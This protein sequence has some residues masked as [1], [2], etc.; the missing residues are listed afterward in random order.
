MMKSE[1]SILVVEDDLSWQRIY[2]AILARQ[3]YMVQVA[4]SKV[5]ALRKLEQYMFDIAVVD[6]R[7]IDEEPKNF[8]G[9]EVVKQLRDRS[10]STR[11]IVNSG[12]LTDEIKSELQVLGV[13]GV[14]KK[15]GKNKE[16]VELVDR[17]RP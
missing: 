9:I 15:H 12:Y 4:S 8:E 1:C 3:G 2:K 16:L 6:L 7:L 13:E 5:E 10:R 14:F 17:L 11:I